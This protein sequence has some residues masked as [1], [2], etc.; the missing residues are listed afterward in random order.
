LPGAE[1]HELVQLPGGRATRRGRSGSSRSRHPAVLTSV[2]SYRGRPGTSSFAS[3]GS[4]DPYEPRAGQ[5][6]RCSRAHGLPRPVTL[7]P[8]GTPKEASGWPQ[9]TRLRAAH[10]SP[11]RLLSSRHLG[12][13]S[14]RSDRR[15]RKWKKWVF[16]KGRPQMLPAAP[17]PR[18][19][20]VDLCRSAVGRGW[21]G[22]PPFPPRAW[23]GAIGR[24]PGLTAF[25]GCASSLL[26]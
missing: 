2:A 10:G 15:R 4:K 13:C 6:F 23:S 21:P 9:A 3:R 22:S 1:L 24:P 8:Q 25:A 18:S 14:A 17:L 26:L 5:E 20:P 7:S 19:R 11:H 16:S 12:P